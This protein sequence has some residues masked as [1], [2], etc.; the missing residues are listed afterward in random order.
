MGD[1]VGVICMLGIKIKLQLKLCLS[2]QMDNLEW[3][4]VNQFDNPGKLVI[5]YKIAS[6][7]QNLAI[8]YCICRI[9][10]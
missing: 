10:L 4:L 9:K 1:G 6:E 2:E 7:C 3:K 8:P 5:E